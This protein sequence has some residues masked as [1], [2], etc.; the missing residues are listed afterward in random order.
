MTDIYL[1]APSPRH[2]AVC[3]YQ[4]GREGDMG[5]HVSPELMRE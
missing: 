4:A 2:K 3:R 5:S 1:I